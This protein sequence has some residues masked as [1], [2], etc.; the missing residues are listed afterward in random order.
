MDWY[1]INYFDIIMGDI[2]SVLYF[3]W[4][5]ISAWKSGQKMK[6]LKIQPWIRKRI[7]LV[8][9]SQFIGMMWPFPYLIAALM[10]IPPM[11]PTNLVSVLFLGVQFFCLTISAIGSYLAWVLPSWYKKRLNKEFSSSLAEDGLSEDEII[12]LMSSA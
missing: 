10:D 11:V 2:S 1:V 9:Y 4:F 7:M 8:Y 6:D 3:G 12:A 5:G